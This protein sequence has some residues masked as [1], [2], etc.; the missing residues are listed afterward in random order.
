MTIEEEVRTF[1]EKYIPNGAQYVTSTLVP[2]FKG[3][4][5]DVFAG[6]IAVDERTQRYVLRDLREIFGHRDKW[7][8]GL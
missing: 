5:E 7:T 3:T 4:W 2:P 8:G 1:A 6:R